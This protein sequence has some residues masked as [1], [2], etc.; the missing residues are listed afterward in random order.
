MKSSTYYFHIKANILADFEICISVLLILQDYFRSMVFV[1]FQN[2]F[3]DTIS[4]HELLVFCCLGALTLTRSKGM[5][6]VDIAGFD[7]PVTDFPALKYPLEDNVEQNKAEEARCL[8]M[9]WVLNQLKLHY[10]EF[11]IFNSNLSLLFWS[12]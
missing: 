2:F 1:V 4:F 12:H 10:Y 3:Q 8:D 5:V 7:W 9:V 6:K 11:Y